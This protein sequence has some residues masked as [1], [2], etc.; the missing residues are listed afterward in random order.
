MIPHHLLF[1]AAAALFFSTAC[2]T[3]ADPDPPDLSSSHEAARARI[4]SVDAAERTILDDKAR[5][6]E[7]YASFQALSSRASQAEI[8]LGLFRLVAMNCLNTEYGEGISD[9]RRVNGLPLSCRSPH[10]DRLLTSLEASPTTSRDDA[11]QL[12]YLIDQIRILRGSLRRRLTR[13]PQIVA[14]H[15]EFI[16]EERALLRQLQ[17]DLERRRALYTGAGWRASFEPIDDHRRILNE[18]SDR[19]DEFA[20]DYPAWPA[21]IELLISTIYFDL[22]DM[23]R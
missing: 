15:R 1:L 18:L 16:I 5:L 2:A 11:I 17:V 8:P 9:V 23:R 6:D 12:L 22:S 3:V 13:I 19:L 14:E 10:L 7:L 4:H 20:R 21:E